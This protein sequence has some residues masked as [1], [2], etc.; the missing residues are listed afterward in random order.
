MNTT[1]RLLPDEAAA[2]LL[3]TGVLENSEPL[4]L[5]A[6][7]QMSEPTAWEAEPLRQLFDEAMKRF[8][9]SERTSAD[10]WLAPVLHA[11]L[12]LTRRQASGSRIWNYV[13]LRL[14][15]DYVYWRHLS[16][17][18]PPSVSRARFSGPFHSQAFARLWWAAELFRDGPDYGPVVVACSN[19]DVLNTVLRLDVI[20]HRPT[21][22]AI[23]KLL[24]TDVIRTG[25]Q[26]NALAQAVNTAGSTLSYEAH[27]PDGL[28]D[29]DAF[30]DWIEELTGVLV[31]YDSLPIGPSDGRT[32]SSSVDIL[33][34]LFTQL[35]AD[36]PSV[37]EMSE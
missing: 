31:P 9:P 21:A 10:A 14:A 28:R 35:F 8:T 29:V 20:L 37:R 27:A 32:R 7:D 25:R 24:T 16:R 11:T 1:V 19:Q 22:Q 18:N 15:P 4:P 3:T 26:V 6:I 5:A 34:T 12:R 13:A 36:S 17:G 33:A 2:R 30:R 23:I